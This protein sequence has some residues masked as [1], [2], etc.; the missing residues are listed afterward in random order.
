[1]LAI[2][3]FDFEDDEIIGNTDFQKLSIKL[4]GINAN[5]SRINT[6]HDSPRPASED[7]VDIPILEP[8]ANDID[9]LPYSVTPGLRKFANSSYASLTRLKILIAVCSLLA[10]INIR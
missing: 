7:V 4:F 9:V 6:L 2:K 3:I 8:F 1:M 10:T 5:S